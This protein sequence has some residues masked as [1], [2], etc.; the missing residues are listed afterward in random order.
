MKRILIAATIVFAN[1]ISISMA[2]EFEINTTLM[3]YTFRIE[4]PTG[5]PKEVTFG[6]CFIM[7]IPEADKPSKAEPVLVTAAHVLENISG[8]KANIY[9]RQKLAEGKFKKVPHELQIRK[10]NK[11]L[12]V[13]HP[14][15]DIAVMKV[16]LPSFVSKQAEEMPM[17]STNLLADDKMMEKYEIHP[18]D[19]L[20]C[21]GY[22]LGV[23]AN[24]F[25]FSIL[26]SGRIASY[27]LTPA[28]DIKSFLF[29]FEIFEG[30]SGG[31]VYFVDKG[32]SYSGTTHLGE[33]IRFVVGIV[34]EQKFGFRTSIATE[35]S[36]ERN[37]VRIDTEREEL[38]LA[39][40]VPAHFIKETLNL[41]T[42]K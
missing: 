9:L 20:L 17:L 2:N 15:A 22:P 5:K 3:H 21:L 25:G 7:G 10:G 8:E 28:R 14:E 27:P 12:W 19:Q 13:R 35:K 34:T 41:L 39:V 4:G 33:E 16:S 11:P 1:L 38:K 18:G 6:T 42:T 24:P 36:R 23:E 26:R 29:D 37:S 40:I 32:R 30:N 31:P